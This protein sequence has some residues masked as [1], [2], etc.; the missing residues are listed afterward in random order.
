MMDHLHRRDDDQLAFVLSAKENV[1]FL[2][3]LLGS[4]IK[5]GQKNK[6]RQQQVCFLLKRK[7]KMN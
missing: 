5:L 4:S 1:T 2:D 7:K 3:N 6:K